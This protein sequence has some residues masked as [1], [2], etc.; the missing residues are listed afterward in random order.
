MTLISKIYTLQRKREGSGSFF[1]YEG[2]RYE[3]NWTANKKDGAGLLITSECQLYE[4]KFVHD[5]MTTV[6]LQQANTTGSSQGKARISTAPEDIIDS[7][8]MKAQAAAQQ[9]TIDQ[10]STAN[11]R[12]ISSASFVVYGNE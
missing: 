12:L 9:T 8:K 2:C 7:K 10:N 1:Y 5:K 4:G 11:T 6:S 3:G